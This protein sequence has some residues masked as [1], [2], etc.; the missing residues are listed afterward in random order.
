MSTVS[1]SDVAAIGPT[2]DH[3]C[4]L[5]SLRHSQRPGCA[6]SPLSCCIARRSVPP[7]VT[8]CRAAGGDSAF[9]P[10]MDAIWTLDKTCADD[11][12]VT[13]SRAATSMTRAR[14]E[15]SLRDA[16]ERRWLGIA[17]SPVG[18]RPAD[19]ADYDN[20]K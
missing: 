3:D 10:P 1:R 7:I 19:V 9:A 20:Q 18:A 15:S 6:V 11:D 8:M 17:Q 4:P 12:H 14:I 13:I 16:K 2:A 5:S